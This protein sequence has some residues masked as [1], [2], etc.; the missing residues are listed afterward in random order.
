MQ[1]ATLV[2]AWIIWFAIVMFN[3]IIFLNF[4][5]AVVSDVFAQ[6]METRSEEHYQMRAKILCELQE[7]FPL[8]ESKK[9]SIL[10]TRH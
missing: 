3:S 7:M 2:A 1:D 4:L 6:V 5:I 8:N 9:A 10:V